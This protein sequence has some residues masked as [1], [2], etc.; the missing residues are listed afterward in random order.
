VL[1]LVA[2]ARPPYVALLLIEPTKVSL[3]PRFLAIVAIA[4]CV[5][6]WSGIGATTSLANANAFMGADPS[7]QLEE[8]KNNP[9]TIPI[10]FRQRL[11]TDVS[12]GNWGWLNVTL[13]T[14][15]HVFAGVMFDVGLGGN[16]C[17]NRQPTD[18]TADDETGT[19]GHCVRPPRATDRWLSIETRF[20]DVT[21]LKNEWPRQQPY[22]SLHEM[23][24][25]ALI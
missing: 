1:S 2:I 12:V 10:A 5:A 7:T 15:Y 20:C 6:V 23:H 9:L 16:A 4:T 14:A 8:L 13:P 25:A 18:E 21:S 17:S 22:F 19:F 11:H 3:Q 24:N